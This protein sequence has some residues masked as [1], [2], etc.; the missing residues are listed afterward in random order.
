MSSKPS[1][2][3]YYS[4][5]LEKVLNLMV[6]SDRCMRMFATSVKTMVEKYDIENWGSSPVADYM[7]GYL[8]AKVLRDFLDKKLK[9]PDQKLVEYARKNKVDG[10]LVTKNELNVL[11][12]LVINFEETKEYLNKNYGFSTLLN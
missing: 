7:D 1:Q 4:V 11:Q 10:V 3:Q 9:E 6:D 2:P 8:N 12:S 5:K